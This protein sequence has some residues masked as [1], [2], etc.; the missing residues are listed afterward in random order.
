MFA[1]ASVIRTTDAHTVIPAGVLLPMNDD[2]TPPPGS[3]IDTIPRPEDR[4]T[5]DLSIEELDALPLGVIT[6][7][8]RGNVVRYNRIEAEYARRTVHSTL[9]KNFFAEIAPCTRV[10]E[11]QGRFN[12][13][14]G[15]NGDGFERFAFTFPF[16][17]GHR[18]VEILFCR[19]DGVEPIDVIVTSRH[20]AVLLSNAPLDTDT[21]ERFVHEAPAGVRL[22]AQDAR[23]HD[24]LLTQTTTWTREL[25]DIC[26]LDP[27]V[28]PPSGGL[29]AYAHLDDAPQIDSLVRAA[30]NARSPYGFEHR[31]IT[32]GGSERF[33]QVHAT[34][35]YG[36]D[37]RA[38]AVNGSASNITERRT[39][40]N[41]LW[42]LA[43]FDRLTG[44]PNRQRFETCLEDTLNDTRTINRMV[45]IVFIDLDRFKSINDTFGHIVG[46]EVLRVV[47]H[48]L[49]TCARAEDVVAR[50]SGDE[51]VILVA[52]F[53]DETVVDAL[54]GCL[55]TSFAQPMQIDDRTLNITA[56]LGVSIFPRH[57]TTVDELIHAADAAMYDTKGSMKSSVVR[58]SDALQHEQRQRATLE[59]DIMVA[60]ADD[61][62]ELYYQPIVD[63]TT[64]QIVGAECLLRWNHPTRGLVSPLEF[65]SVAETNGSML[66]IG[67]WVLGEACREIRRRIDAGHEPIPFSVN[68]SLVQFRS[69]DL[70][71]TVRRA[72]ADSGIKPELLV[73]EL[74][75]SVASGNFY[76]TMRMLAELKLLGVKL[77]IDDFGTGYSS[78]AYLKHFPIDV[79]KL[80]RSF[81][82]EIT[83]DPLDRAIAETVVTLANKLHLQVV[84]EGVETLEQAA[85]MVEIGCHRMQGY[86]FGRPVPAR[87]FGRVSIEVS[88]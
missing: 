29:R 12:D 43:N 85:C 23:W 44:V 56:S 42:R 71:E 9:G 70:V 38:I 5:F 60:L 25:Y 68:V 24:D 73:L 45:A 65:I 35:T 64:R 53:D 33:V 41:R 36:S 48:R 51:F 39:E 13:F 67:A 87:E 80:D 57:G 30:L 50:L 82:M 81:V 2:M 69:P 83:S 22:A 61:Q 47:A 66:P 28:V 3:A 8:R 21:V 15:V 84:A 18:E 76:E 49:A 4:A 1:A 37:G 86:L 78:L 54:C 59:Q 75:E 63:R 20:S 62:F 14:A 77:A 31:I 34:V 11:F 52:G 88:G 26:E 16:R 55:L 46:D 79:I 19:R 32:T 6:L 58:Y 27:R 10:K 74:T 17:W 40:E 72:L 7:D